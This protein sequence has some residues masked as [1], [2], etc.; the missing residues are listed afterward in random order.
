MHEFDETTVELQIGDE[1]FVAKGK[2]VVRK[3]WKVLF[4]KKEDAAEKKGE[5]DSSSQT[6]PSLTKGETVD[7]KAVEGKEDKTKPPA[8]FTEGTLIAAM[9]NIWRSFEDPQLQAKLKEA[10]GIGTPATRAAIIQELKR[11]TY[12]AS[13]PL[14]RAR[15]KRTSEGLSQGAKRRDDGVLRD[16]AATR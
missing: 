8:Y 15:T 12:L 1:K 5:D 11:K 7:V 10:G 6:L 9:E 14:H 16:E 13:A 3:G 4:D 2:V